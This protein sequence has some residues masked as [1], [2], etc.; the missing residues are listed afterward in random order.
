MSAK[1]QVRRIR[2]FVVDGWAL[3]EKGGDV[4]NPSFSRPQDVTTVCD[5]S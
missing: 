4:S 2:V 5:S 3:V 1:R